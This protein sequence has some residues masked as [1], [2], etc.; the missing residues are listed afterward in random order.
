MVDIYEDIKN[1]VIKN[2]FQLR[3]RDGTFKTT[4]HNRFN[5]S[6]K[7][8]SKELVNNNKLNILEIGPSYGFSSLDIYN[9]FNK[10]KF[11]INLYSYEKN[12]YIFFKEIIFK[13]ILLFEKDYLIGFYL[14]YFRKFIRL[15]P[16]RRN[17]FLNLSSRF[18]QMLWKILYRTSNIKNNSRSIKLISS[19]L[20]EKNIKVTD[21]LEEI[22]NIEFNVLICFNVLNK[23]YYSKKEAIINLSKF[24]NLLKN[25]SYLL[26]GRNEKIY[27]S[28]SIYKFT[29]KESKLFLIKKLNKG[30]DFEESIIYLKE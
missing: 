7:I 11:N 13:N 20:L 9:F 2:K 4:S 19:K 6:L 23:S 24:C 22:K 21:K 26:I 30:W 14:Y 8:L 28:S 27:E 5:N 25:D 16:K 18:F 17:I 29:K 12:L 10:R 3:L 1:F 15:N